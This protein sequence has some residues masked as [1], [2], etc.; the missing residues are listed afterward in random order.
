MTKT[1][2]TSRTI[3]SQEVIA[4]NAF[5]TDWTDYDE[6]TAIIVLNKRSSSNALKTIKFIESLYNFKSKD[7]YNQL[8]KHFLTLA[9]VRDIPLL[10]LSYAYKHDFLIKHLAPKI[11][12][13]PEGSKVQTT[14]VAEWANES[15]SGTLKEITA[16]SVAKNVLSS[17]KQGGFV[18]GKVKNIRVRPDVTWLHVVNAIALD[19][20]DG[21]RGNKLLDGPSLQFF[22]LDEQKIRQLIHEAVLELYLKFAET[23]QVVLLE[24]GPKLQPY[25]NQ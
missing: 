10:C 24:P 2:H 4:L 5:Y 12:G 8:F 23:G 19:Y 25:L 6:N 1:I 13:T 20:K 16:M 7:P 22:R 9:E 3:M 15:Y 17:F 11:L 21:L 14:R 18:L